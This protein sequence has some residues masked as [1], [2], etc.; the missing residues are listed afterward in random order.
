MALRIVCISDTHGLHRELSVPAGDLL[1]HAGDLTRRGELDELRDLNAWLGTLPHPHKVVIAGNHDWCCQQ[2]P[3]RARELV[4]DAIYLE[5]EV[6]LIAGLRIYGSP[7]THGFGGWAFTRRPMALAYHWAELPDGLDLLLTHGPPLGAQDQN[8]KGEHLGDAALA[9]AVR[10]VGP[11]L[12]VFGHIHE[13][14]GL[15]TA[16]GTVFINASV[17][18]AIYES[19]Q[20]PIVVEL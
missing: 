11:R 3:E 13:G 4:T 9:E 15:T 6:C 5:D 8:A 2:E 7:W 14:Y 20:A 16:S 1:V 12:H 10:R 18:T 19:I 17:C